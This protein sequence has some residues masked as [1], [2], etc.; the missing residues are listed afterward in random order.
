MTPWCIHVNGLAWIVLGLDSVYPSR[1][2]HTVLA[3]NWTLL[4]VVRKEGRGGATHPCLYDRELAFEVVKVNIWSTATTA[5]L[6]RLRGGGMMSSP[7]Q[8]HYYYPAQ[9]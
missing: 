8:R 6:L 9:F 5:S 1:R 7:A 4:L 2:I 3:D